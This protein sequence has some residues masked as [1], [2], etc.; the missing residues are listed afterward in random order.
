[1]ARFEKKGKLKPRF[2]GPFE[3]LKKVIKVAYGLALP[4]ELSH[5]HGVFYVSTLRQYLQD[6]SHVLEYIPLDI[7]DDP[8]YDK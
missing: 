8:S 2:I 5:V 7:R 4:Q 3:V 6:S 1:M